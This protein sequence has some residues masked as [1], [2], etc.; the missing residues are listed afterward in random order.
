MKAGIVAPEIE[1]EFHPLS[2]NVLNRH[3]KEPSNFDS[4]KR[5]Y[6]LTK[7]H[8][9]K[10]M[11]SIKMSRIAPLWGR[12]HLKVHPREH[13][14]WGYDRRPEAGQQ[15]KTAGK[16]LKGQEQPSCHRTPLIVTTCM[17]ASLS[18]EEWTNTQAS[19]QGGSED[20]TP[21]PPGWSIVSPPIGKV[22]LWLRSLPLQSRAIIS[23]QD[24][25]CENEG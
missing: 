12:K 17:P 7:Y 10:M 3:I 15:Q 6:F 4:H 19:L 23:T 25:G 16:Q 18:Q 14:F 20:E 24:E 9:I 13:E 11:M 2:K 5:R 22:S 1:E 21:G 8:T